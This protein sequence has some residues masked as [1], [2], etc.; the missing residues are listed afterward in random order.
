MQLTLDGCLRPDLALHTAQDV[1]SALM[2][3]C[4]HN[5]CTGGVCVG[6]LAHQGKRDSAR[7]SPSERHGV[8]LAKHRNRSKVVPSPRPEITK[9]KVTNAKG[10]CSS[11][12]AGLS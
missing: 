6:E 3:I 4:N 9:E 1:T 10:V 8:E 11:M 7:R 12:S 5:E 2:H